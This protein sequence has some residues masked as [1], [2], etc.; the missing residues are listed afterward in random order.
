[1]TATFADLVAAIDRALAPGGR[2]YVDQSTRMQGDR[3]VCGECGKEWPTL[4]LG[5][6]FEHQRCGFWNPSCSGRITAIW[7]VYPGNVPAADHQTRG[8]EES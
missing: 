3:F 8:E 1:M 5:P 2:F 7:D 6:P 4:A